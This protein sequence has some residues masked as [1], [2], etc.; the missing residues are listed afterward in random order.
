MTKP[1]LVGE[2]PSAQGDGRPFTGPSGDRLQALL[3]L[4]SYDELT[5]AFEMINIFE[6]ITKPA[7][8]RFDRVYARR[9]AVAL[10]TRWHERDPDDILDVI[11]AGRKVMAAFGVEHLPWFGFHNLGGVVLWAFPHPS[12]LNHF[13]NNASEQLRASRF[14]RARVLSACTHRPRAGISLDQSISEALANDIP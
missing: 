10:L 11:L 9:R 8:D 5:Q 4:E 12:G 7:W 13:W 6:K 3:G 14:L 2:A 1:I